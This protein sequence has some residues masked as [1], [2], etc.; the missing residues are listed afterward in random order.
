LTPLEAAERLEKL[1]SAINDMIVRIK[2]EQDRPTTYA[3]TYE[4]RAELGRIVRNFG[5]DRPDHN[6]ADT[7]RH[8]I[9]V[10]MQD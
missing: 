5:Y 10:H 3:M 4:L 1:K 9:N 6:L 8:L 7:A 2:L